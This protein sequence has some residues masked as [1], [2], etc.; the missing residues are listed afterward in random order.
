MTSQHLRAARRVLAAVLVSAAPGWYAA[1]Q[2]VV[3]QPKKDCGLNALYLLLD[4][5]GHHREL[6]SLVK[7]LPERHKD[8]YS[9]AELQTASRSSG[10]PLQG[11]M[12]T[13][14]DLPLSTP[15]IAFF[16]THRPDG[17]HFVVLVPAGTTGKM[18]Q[19]IDPPYAPA[20]LDYTRIF[21]V[22]NSM[23][24]LQPWSPWERY[25]STATVLIGFLIVASISVFIVRSLPRRRRLS[26]PA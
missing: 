16:T 21:G 19:V 13:H 1:G 4:L 5:T 24:I 20:I 9:L 14:A 10:L 2:E 11:R 7:M 6:E 23:V 18:A 17:G 22:D 15:V 3:D 25:Q 26:I 12:I 8:G